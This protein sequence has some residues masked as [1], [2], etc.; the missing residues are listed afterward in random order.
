MTIAAIQSLKAN[1][2]GVEHYM[3]QLRSP[4]FGKDADPEVLRSKFL[5]LQRRFSEFTKLTNA[6]KGPPELRAKL[7]VLK[8]WLDKYSDPEKYPAPAHIAIENLPQRYKNKNVTLDNRSLQT[9]AYFKFYITKVFEYMSKLHSKYTE[10][11]DKISDILSVGQTLHKNLDKFL[12]TQ[13]DVPSYD[14]FAA[15][16]DDEI[17]GDL[18]TVSP[19]KMIKTIQ[20]ILNQFHAFSTKVADSYNEVALLTKELDNVDLG[21]FFTRTNQRNSMIKKLLSNLVEINKTIYQSKLPS[22]PLFRQKYY[23]LVEEC[24][25]LLPPHIG[26][27]LSATIA[28][29]KDKGRFDQ[30]LEQ[31]LHGTDPNKS[32]AQMFSSPHLQYTP[33]AETP[34]AENTQQ[35]RVDRAL[36]FEEIQDLLN[37]G[38]P[39]NPAQR[40]QYEELWAGKAISPAQRVEYEKLWNE[41]QS[42]KRMMKLASHYHRK[43]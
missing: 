29:R 30:A 39:L 37:R 19:A 9:I 1:I 18:P 32:P 5:L 15:D 34:I 25:P 20:V 41:A 11:K 10:L 35:A 43:Y 28:P 36:R 26:R 33:P 16:D 6:G 7:K 2:A 8:K 42:H 31:A 4:E 23:Q 38:E 24:V 40:K 3:Q 22:A 14:Y 12:I 21:E 13:D 27:E 17:T